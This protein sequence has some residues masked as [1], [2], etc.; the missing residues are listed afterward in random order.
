MSYLPFKELK[1]G[2]FFRDLQD[3]ALYL[4]TDLA[5][6]A[7]LMESIYVSQGSKQVLL[8]RGTCQTLYPNICVIAEASESITLPTVRTDPRNPNKLY[9]SEGQTRLVG[10]RTMRPVILFAGLFI[11]DGLGSGTYFSK[12]GESMGVAADAARAMAESEGIPFVYIDSFDYQPDPTLADQRRAAQE[13][14][15]KKTGAATA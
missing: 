13:A 6:K 1:V 12:S 11:Y 15:D 5:G 9:W 4:K 2:A 8:P 14:F 7:V 3:N 10:E